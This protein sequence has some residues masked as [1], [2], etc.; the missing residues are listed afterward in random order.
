MDTDAGK[1][2]R[3]FHF[4]DWKPPATTRIR[5]RAIRSPSGTSSARAARTVGGSLKVTTT[6]LKAGYLRKN[7]VPYS[8]QRRADRILRYGP[9]AQRRSCCWW[10]P[11]PST[12]P[13]YLREPFIIS[14]AVQE[15][16]RRHRLEAVGV[17]VDDGEGEASTMT[18]KSKPSC[19]RGDAGRA[20]AFRPWREV[21]LSGSWAAKNHEDALE[22]GAGPEPRRLRRPTVQRIRARQSPQLYAIR[23]LH[24]RADLLVLAR[25]GTSPTARSA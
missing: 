11:S 10:S 14:F 17:F 6:H 15:A 8:E 3:L 13:M 21:D 18:C 1:Q 7:G 19:S 4:G 22:R 12:D 24:A 23:H 9:R 20:C 2:T 25:S 16:G 5:C